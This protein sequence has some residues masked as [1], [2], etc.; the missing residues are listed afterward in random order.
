VPGDIIEHM[1]EPLPPIMLAE[2]FRSSGWAFVASMLQGPS[3]AN[4]VALLTQFDAARLQRDEAVYLAAAAQRAVR[5]LE[6]LVVGF[7]AAAAGPQPGDRDVD[8]AAEEI[9]CAMRLHPH[10][11]RADVA[12]ARGLAGRLPLTR[13]FL[14]AGEISLRQARQVELATRELEPATVSLVEADAVPGDPR[15]LTFRL[16]RALVRHAPEAV[17]K[18]AEENRRARR[19]D[20]WSDPVE[21]VA[22][23]GVQGPLAQLAQIKAAIDADA[24]TR[25]A[26]ECRTLTTRRFDVLLGWARQRLGLDEPNPSTGTRPEQV[27]AATAA[28][29]PAPASSRCTSCGRSGR[30]RVPINVTVSLATLLGLSEA[31]GSLDG[32]PIPADVARELAADGAW[33]RWLIEPLS[34]GLLDIG[35]ATYRPG[36]RVD[37][38]VR[39]RDCTCRFPGCEQPAARC[40]LDHTRAFHTQNG[41]TVCDNLVALCRRH[42]RLK[43]EKD[44]TYRVDPDGGVTWTAPSG[45]TY[46]QPPED[47][48]DDELLSYEF[49][50]MHVRDRVK[51]DRGRPPASTVPQ[52]GRHD[53]PPF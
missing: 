34:G 16:N 24:H 44:W 41:E 3:S 2:D 45:N 23:I 4:S 10:A 33:R 28:A 25:V 1:F 17:K 20:F 22:G 31:S 40:D 19:V 43:H 32:V 42:H 52:A 30:S 49:A 37:R 46:R 50:R 13:R 15:R 7:Q 38:F 29:A 11:A 8:E 26:G 35:S 12:A 6:A 48:G 39:G 9:A 21:G 18:K 36:S 51:R 27:P 47:H 53:V 14:E 5:M